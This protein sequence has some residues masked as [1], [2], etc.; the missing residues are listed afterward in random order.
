MHHVCINKTAAADDSETLLAAF[1]VLDPSGSGFIDANV[2]HEHLST[3]G[4]R[5][6][7]G[8]RE[9]EMTDFIE[10]AKD[11]DSPDSTK[12]YYEDYVAKLNDSIEKHIEHLYRDARGST[13]GP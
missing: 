1:R 3:R 8:F 6:A 9:K 5:Q 7:D 11:K 10:Y 12:I 2:M 13:L 4:G